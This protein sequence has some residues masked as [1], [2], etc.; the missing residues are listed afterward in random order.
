VNAVYAAI[1]GLVEGLTEFLPISSTAHLMLTT[2]LLHL[3]ETA[4]HKTSEVVIQLGAILAVVVL[5][6]RALFVE[7]AV[8]KR[9]AIA[10]FPTGLLGLLLHD[11]VKRYLL[12]NLN[13]ALAALAV[14]GVILIVYEWLHRER[15]EDVA[16]LAEIPYWKAFVIGAAQALA[17]IPGVSRSAATV[18]CGLSLGVKRRTSVEFS[19]L[20]A[21]PTM[22]AASGYTLYKQYKEGGG[23]T[24]GESWFLGIGFVISFIVAVLTIRFLLGFVKTHT[25]LPFG[26]YRM[27]LV[28][29]VVILLACGVISR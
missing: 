15:P 27:L 25:F 17:M 26:V 29:G 23:L 24:E 4:A 22:L 12:E 13:V 6:W 28:V 3:E 14:G 7:W 10:F 1:M 20:L 5:Y 16:A 11:V 2:R 21:V 19:F 9:V 8:M 18:I